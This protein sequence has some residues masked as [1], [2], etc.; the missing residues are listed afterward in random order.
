MRTPRGE[1][2][3]GEDFTL[4]MENASLRAASTLL[5]SAPTQLGWNPW[6][7]TDLAAG[8]STHPLA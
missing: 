5:A 3:V 6:P 8:P 7:Q 4:A 2:Q 1:I